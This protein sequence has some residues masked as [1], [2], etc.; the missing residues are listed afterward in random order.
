MD[1]HLEDVL[2]GE[3]AGR[4][5]PRLLPELAAAVEEGEPRR[6]EQVLEHAGG[7]EVDAERLHVDRQRAD[8]LVRVEQ[9][10]HAALVR[11][12]DDRLH[13]ELRAVAVADV[14]DRDE[15]RL[16][17]DGLAEVLRRERSVVGLVHVHDARAA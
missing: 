14:R 17:V 5:R 6:A 2:V 16:L 10:G 1:V 12:R 13:V 8:R 15:L 3:P 7:E 11:D 4:R 9:D